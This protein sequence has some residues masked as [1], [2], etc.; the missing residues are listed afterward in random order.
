MTNLRNLLLAVCLP[1]FLCAQT[2]SFPSAVATDAQLK[3]AANNLQTT[4][5]GSITAAQT[6]I[7]VRDA[8]GIAANMLLS[9][10]N[11]IVSVT[12]VAG[13]VLTVVRGFD[14]TTAVAHNPNRPVQARVAAWHHNSLKEEI[15]AVQTAL[16]PGLSNVSPTQFQ[17]G[18]YS[19]TQSPGGSLTSA[20]VN[21]VTLTPCPTGVAGT[22]PGH[23]VYL[24]GGVGAAEVVLI[25]GGTCT[26][27][28][29]SGTLTFT[30]ANNHSGAWTIAAA[31]GGIAEALCATT[32]GGSITA[33]TGTVVRAPVGWCGNTDLE[34]RLQPNVTLSGTGS[35]PANTATNQ[36]LW[37]ELRATRTGT[38]RV[39]PPPVNSATPGIAVAPNGA[40]IECAATT[41]SCIQEA[42]D[43][44]GTYGYDLRIEGGNDLDNATECGGSATV[45]GP[46]CGAVV[47]NINAGLNF[48]PMQG[49]RIS[50]GA[51]TFNCN[52]NVG[53]APCM[54]FDSALM[55]DVD[56]GGSQ[57]V[58]F[59]SGVCNVLFQPSNP[60][61]VDGLTTIAV[62]KYH[63]GA[64]AGG[65]SSAAVCFNTGAAGA[66]IDYNE[67]SFNEVNSFDA[68]ASLDPLN[69][70]AW[71]PYGILAMTP[72]GTKQFRNN[73]VKARMVHGCSASC[74]QVGTS[75]PPGAWSG[76]GSTASNLGSNIWEIGGISTEVQTSQALNTYGEGDLFTIGALDGTNSASTAHITFQ[77]SAAQNLLS[78][79]QTETPLRL[80]DGSWSV[81]NVV[82]ARRPGIHS[83][84]AATGSPM[85]IPEYADANVGLTSRRHKTVIAGGTVSVVNIGRVTGIATITNAVNSGGGLIR[86]TTSAAHGA[87]TGNAVLVREVGGVTNANGNWAEVTVINATTLELVASTFA[88]T[89]TSGGKLS[90]LE[91]AATGTT[92]GV[93]ELDPGEF[94]RVTYSSAPTITRI[95]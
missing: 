14:G 62:S 34:L 20:I 21:A 19:W 72:T 80:V 69:P 68:V 6:T 78:I 51:V 23:Y 91:L 9:I 85:L 31:S 75:A 30:P 5:D 94:L 15:K 61:P 4:L 86:L 58:Y 12:S 83:N 49:K 45:G 16:G 65:G 11:E 37:R 18:P 41:T 70:S 1:A 81:S 7:T 53:S 76:L 25:T 57:V 33:V 13:R 47:H 3:V 32:S 84:M 35:M 56:F 22:N 66:T 29:A 42:I 82:N 54:T 8:T 88:G 93:Y 92:A 46:T 87:V 36:V 39:L 2:A 28:A 95:K 67:F 64:V 48:P 74:I 55:A 89:Y 79:G 44:A 10:D 71:K 24:S 63:F 43:Y 40:L 59:G 77:G 26:S 17:A 52:V 38:V 90:V 50:S 73:T 27:G 60:V